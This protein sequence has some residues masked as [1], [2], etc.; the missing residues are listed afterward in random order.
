MCNTG[1]RFNLKGKIIPMLTIKMYSLYTSH[2]PHFCSYGVVLI[3]VRADNCTVAESKSISRMH[4]LIK[5]QAMKNYGV[6]I[7]VY[8]CFYK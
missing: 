4:F 6:Q 5:H 1:Y 2:R 8:I 7:G 3:K